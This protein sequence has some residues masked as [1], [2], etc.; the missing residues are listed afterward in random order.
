MGEMGPW[1]ECETEVG[2]G[3]ALRQRGFQHS[4]GASGRLRR[5]EGRLGRRRKE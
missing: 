1:G 5:G 4:M 3:G 2:G